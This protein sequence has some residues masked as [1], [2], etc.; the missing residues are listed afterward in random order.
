MY[1]N[2]FITSFGRA[3]VDLT[4]S[5]RCCLAPRQT[6]P[7]FPSKWSHNLG[8][9]KHACDSCE[10][11]TTLARRKIFTRSKFSHVLNG[12]KWPDVGDARVDVTITAEWLEHCKWWIITLLIACV[13]SS[14]SIVNFQ[15]DDA[16]WQLHVPC[17]STVQ[18]E[19]Y[20]AWT[21]HSANVAVVL[22]KG[23]WFPCIFAA[24]ILKFF[25]VS[26]GLSPCRIIYFA[27]EDLTRR[28]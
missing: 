22:N 23:G 21:S 24:T 4:T 16:T 26:Y 13:R 19:D 28:N 7:S 10:V 20:S 18:D 27:M 1:G 3:S 6:I 15:W 11:E 5:P 9:M 8:G 12:S 17:V 2:R 14:D 25:A